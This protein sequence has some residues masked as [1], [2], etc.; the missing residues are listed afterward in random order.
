VDIVHKV[1]R[2]QVMQ[3]T[4]YLYFNGRCEEALS[5]YQQTIGARVECQMRFSDC[6]GELDPNMVPPGTEHRIMHAAFKLGETTIFAADGCASAEMKPAGFGLSLQTPD[7]AEA[8]QLF[9]ALAW[10]GEVRM[11]MTKTFFSPSFGIVV[12]KFG[13]NWLIYVP[14]AQ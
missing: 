9:N 11:A 2:R 10:E 3:V 1:I 6:P 12:D 5:F 7:V 8:E 14:Q 4:P 13:V